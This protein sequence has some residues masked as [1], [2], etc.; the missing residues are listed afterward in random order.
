MRRLFLLGLACAGIGAVAAP[1]GPARTRATPFALSGLVTGPT[2]F[3]DTVLAGSRRLEAVRRAG[4]WGGN[5]TA[6]DGEV[7]QIFVS[8]AYPVDPTIP[9]SVAE[10]MIQL[11]HGP[12][13][14]QAIVY[15]APLAEVQRICGPDAGG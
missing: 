7:L 5:I 1:A 3:H 11:Y 2:A 4:E 8:D 10:F 14:G 13:I 12:E 15:I 6:S 9:Q